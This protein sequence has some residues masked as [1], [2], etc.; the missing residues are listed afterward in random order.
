M[1]H[2]H[3]LVAAALLRQIECGLALEVP[4]ARVRAL[5]QE[6]VGDHQVALLDAF[7]PVAG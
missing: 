4:R 6:G 3:D 5:G 1:Q 2:F 7:D